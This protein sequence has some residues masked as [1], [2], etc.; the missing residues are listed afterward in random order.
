MDGAVTLRD[1]R[2]GD[3]DALERLENL[4]FDGDRLS[5][6][7]LRHFL[8][9]R[10]TAAPVAERDGALAGYAMVGFRAGSR[11]GRLFSLAVDPGHGRLGV[12][13]A[14]VRA[15]EDRARARGCTAVRLEVRADNAGAVALYRAADYRQF[16]TLE[17]YYEDGGAALRFERALTE[18]A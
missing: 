16:G 12:G 8:R 15:C 3:L 14:L 9:A 2:P 1:G 7:S 13:R 18:G 10:S 4:V 11:L 6:R 5:R 17:D